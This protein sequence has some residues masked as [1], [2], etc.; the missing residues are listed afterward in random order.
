MRE[1]RRRQAEASSEARSIE[2]SWMAALARWVAQLGKARRAAVRG[3]VGE[4]RILQRED[5]EVGHTRVAVLLWSPLPVDPCF[6]FC[7]VPSSTPRLLLFS[8]WTTPSCVYAFS[9]SRSKKRHTRGVGLRAGGRGRHHPR[10]SPHRSPS[11]QKTLQQTCCSMKTA[12]DAFF[13]KQGTYTCVHRA[14]CSVTQLHQQTETRSHPMPSLWTP[15][16]VRWLPPSRGGAERS[17][18]AGRSCSRR[19][20]QELPTLRGPSATACSALAASF[21]S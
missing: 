6:F 4:L 1:L 18:A 21:W 2:R 14:A 13:A 3:E 9:D 11:G 8:S 20:A 16:I 19:S 15:E 10:G 17:T 5:A 12:F 7:L